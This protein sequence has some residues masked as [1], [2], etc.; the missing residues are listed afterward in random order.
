MIFPLD[1]AFNMCWIVS[2]IYCTTLYH[3][4]LH[5]ASRRLAALQCTTLRFTMLHCIT[6]TAPCCIA[7][8]HISLHRITPHL[9]ALSPPIR[10]CIIFHRTTLLYTTPHHTAL[11]YIV[12]HCTDV[13]R[14]LLHRTASHYHP[15]SGGGRR[16]CWSDIDLQLRHRH[17]PEILPPHLHSS[18][19]AH[20]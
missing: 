17:P 2:S 18:A 15:L 10:F 20:V 5:F 13:H 14:I 11:H 4:I 19:T 16:Q 6:L 7:I 3:T 8:S 1:H 12:S 9:F